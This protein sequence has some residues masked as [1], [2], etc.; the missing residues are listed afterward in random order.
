MVFK[1]DTGW[2][3]EQGTSHSMQGSGGSTDNLGHWLG[4]AAPAMP[5]IVYC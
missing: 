5:A 3:S 1:G 4:A 2:T